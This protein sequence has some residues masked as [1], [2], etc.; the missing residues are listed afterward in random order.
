MT[1]RSSWTDVGWTSDGPNKS[2]MDRNRHGQPSNNRP[3][4][5]ASI[6]AGDR[7]PAPAPVVLRLTRRVALSTREP[8]MPLPLYLESTIPNER[9]T[10]P[11]PL[12][13]PVHR[14][15]SLQ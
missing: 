1:T 14:E 15:A 8:G 2:A 12:H 5:A 7:S 3:H 9:I 4:Y 10:Q 11:I 6:S 13:W